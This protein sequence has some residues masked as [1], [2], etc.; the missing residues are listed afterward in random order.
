MTEKLIISQNPSGPETDQ[1][2]DAKRKI[3]VSP[4]GVKYYADYVGDAP[5]DEE[6]R[7]MMEPT[8]AENDAQAK[9]STKAE[10]IRRLIH[11]DDPQS[12]AARG[13]FRALLKLMPGDRKWTDLAAAAKAEIT[14]ETDA[15]V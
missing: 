1:W 2:P 7:L 3:W 15:N 6:I 10:A 8:P 13:L 11:D 12:V 4:K 14:A 5:T 9:A